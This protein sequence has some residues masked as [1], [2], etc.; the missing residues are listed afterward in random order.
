MGIPDSEDGREQWTTDS[1]VY[2]LFVNAGKPFDVKNP[3]AVK[4]VLDALKG[5]LTAYDFYLGMEVPVSR[6]EAEKIL[7][8]EIHGVWLR[9]LPC[10]KS[11][12]H[13]DMTPSMPWMKV[14][15]IWRYSLQTN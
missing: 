10:R 13:G 12:G 11:S 2:D 15:N 9:H 4:D 7:E 1:Y 5:Q 14:F 8:G 3:N 6:E